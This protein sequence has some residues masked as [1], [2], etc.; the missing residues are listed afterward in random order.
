MGGHAHEHFHVVLLQHS[1]HCGLEMIRLPKPPSR[2]S[3]TEFTVML[4]F[5]MALQAL[6]IDAMLPAL[7]DIAAELNVTNENDRQLV[8][9]T[10]LMG[11]GAGALVFG[12][13]ADRFGRKP[14]VLAGIGTYCL[15]DFGCMVINDFNALLM[16]RFANGM[17]A[18]A[19]SVVAN[20]IVRDRFEGDAMARV[21]SMIAVVFMVVPVVAPTIGQMILLVAG[22]RSIFGLMFV[23]GVVM[24]LW[25]LFRL[26]ETL[27]QHQKQPL[28]PRLILN[29]LRLVM[30]NRDAFGYIYG[31]TLVFAGLYGYINCAEQLVGEHF[32]L[33]EN[34]AYV[35]GAMAL[36][37]AMA[38]F[39]N[40]RI[41]ERFGARRV[42]HTAL[43]IF[44]LTGA[45][46]LVA[47]TLAPDNFYIFAPLMTINLALIGFLG[48]NFSSIALQ[49]FRHFAGSASS[50]Q[51]TVRVGGGA[52]LGA[53]IGAAYDGT[54]GPLG[55][56]LFSLSLMGLLLILYSERGKL[57]RRRKETVPQVEG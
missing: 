6:G 43:L 25:V 41:V 51:T 56:A 15:F 2:L 36:F 8:V 1:A 23:T 14:V 44:V 4:A 26:P 17:V 34:F 5:I 11:M 12:F 46:Q 35:F 3:R 19:G 9:G 24:F 38:S 40:S 28:D 53:V 37:M 32:G 10:Y 39:V 55:L 42:S 54:A 31:A 57:F 20:A 27:A 49:P 50:F 29:N 18:S 45:A 22:W 33:G 30:T 7:G 47:A 48:S 21:V 16:L 13:L 52:L